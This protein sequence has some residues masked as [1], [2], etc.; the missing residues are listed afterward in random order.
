MPRL[1]VHGVSPGITTQLPDNP[2]LI[3][4]DWTNMNLLPNII[5]AIAALVAAY[6]WWQT[7]KVRIISDYTEPLNEDV[8]YLNF[9]GA[10]G[11]ILIE[12]DGTRIDITATADRKS[13]V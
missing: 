1:R 13:V 2:K 3:D 4:F 8:T 7:S 6:F 12:P 10:R 11:P 9:M 5:S